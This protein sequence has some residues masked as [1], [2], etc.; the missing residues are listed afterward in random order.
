MREVDFIMEP[1][2]SGSTETGAWST[3]EVILDCCGGSLRQAT[4]SLAD[5]LRG[6]YGA[7]RFVLSVVDDGATRRLE[8]YCYR[9]PPSRAVVEPLDVIRRTAAYFPT[10]LAAALPGIV[11]E[12]EVTSLELWEA[13]LDG[14]RALEYVDIYTGFSP[15][16]PR[17]GLS[18]RLHQDGRLEHRNI[19]CFADPRISPPASVIGDIL[20]ESFHI[21]P[22]A[23]RLISTVV[24]SR[25]LH[26]AIKPQC[27][28]LYFG[29]L[30]HSMTAT[31]LS[32]VSLLRDVAELLRSDPSTH[33]LSF[34]VGVDFCRD[35]PTKVALF[36]S[37]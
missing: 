35:E 20:A 1:R 7:Q 17:G 18:Y 25:G 4:R 21:G 12:A 15:I 37:F 33:H 14:D 2:P 28:G 22:C 9:H 32:E 6:R 19:Y 29:H 16:R 3:F 34:D 36:G 13:S 30:D 26:Y 23:T 8:L 10:D 31:L 11:S 5:D 27:D 24:A